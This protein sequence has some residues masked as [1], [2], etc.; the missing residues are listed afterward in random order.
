MAVERRRGGRRGGRRERRR[1]EREGGREG[2]AL[3][4]PILTR[5]KIHAGHIFVSLDAAAATRE[6]RGKGTQLRQKR[7]LCFEGS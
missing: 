6:V 5:H 2:R 7:I 4:I 1:R 3:Q